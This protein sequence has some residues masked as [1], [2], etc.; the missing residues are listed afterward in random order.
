MV[1][2]KPHAKKQLQN[3]TEMKELSKCNTATVKEVSSTNIDESKLKMLSGTPNQTLALDIIFKTMLATPAPMHKDN[4]AELIIAAMQE[5]KPQNSLEGMLCSQLVSL[6]S[7]GMTYLQ[8]S[9]NAEMRF[10]QDPDLNNA[11][12]LLRLQHE[13]IECLMKLRRNGEQKVIVQH[14]QVN[15][16]GQ[17][18]VGSILQGGG[19]NNK[20]IARLSHD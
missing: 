9:E 1:K 17:A 6:H 13:T 11:V 18:I 5:L 10:H 12:K 3:T 2:Y 19:V 15:D 14:V 16:G 4:K 7:L 8:R 20:K